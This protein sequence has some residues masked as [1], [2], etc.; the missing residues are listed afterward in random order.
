MRPLL[1]L[2]TA[3]MLALPATAQEDSGDIY[4]KAMELFRAQKYEQAVPLFRAA[5]DT[6]EARYGEES[7]LLALD[8]NN[9]AEVYRLTRRYDEAEP[10]YKRAITL[11]ESAG[12]DNPGLAT[13]LNNLALLYRAQGRLKEAEPLYKRALVLLEKA[14]GPSHPDVAK[15]L[16]NLAVLYRME[17]APEKAQP[18]QERALRIAMDSLGPD[19]PTTKLMERN[20]ELVGSPPA[21]TD[22]AAIGPPAAGPAKPTTQPGKKPAAAAKPAAPKPGASAATPRPAPAKPAPTKQAAVSPPAVRTGSG[23]FSVHVASV[24]AAGEVAAEWRRL[25]GLHPGLAAL[26]LQPPQS[27]QIA[28]RGI[29]YRVAGGTFPNKAAAEAACERLKP[30]HQYCR[31]IEP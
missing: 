17:S 7:P 16:N 14:L 11:D 31:V 4:R 1:L 10:L 26:Q 3:L 6:A 20:L 29:Y 9:L 8:L 27:I 23:R 30:E 21:E 24:R 19:H 13:S 22:M 5:L 15:S 2:V 12:E 28:G 18:L 25:I